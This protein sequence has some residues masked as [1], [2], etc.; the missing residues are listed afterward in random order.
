M[1]TFVALVSMTVSASAQTPTRVGLWGDVA[2]G[3]G[4]H[5]CETCDDRSGGLTGE[6][7]IGGTLNPNLRIALALNAWMGQTTTRSG[8]VV[9]TG[10]DLAAT[11]MPVLQ[12]YPARSA[13]LFLRGGA[14]F[15]LAS[16]PRT[17]ARVHTGLSNLVGIGY[18]ITAGNTTTVTAFVSRVGI[19]SNPNDTDFWQAVIAVTIN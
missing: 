17:I 8:A 13:R 2:V 1:A 7:A 16:E 10:T 4:S 19:L 18:D 15:G 11:L 6:F 12:I 3:W 14:G 5:G 9:D